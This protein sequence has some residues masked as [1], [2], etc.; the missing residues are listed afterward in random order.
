MNMDI[1]KDMA[2]HSTGKDDFSSEAANR[3]LSTYKG[4]NPQLGLSYIVR[5]HD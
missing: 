3:S 1:D 4:Y 2:R 5:R